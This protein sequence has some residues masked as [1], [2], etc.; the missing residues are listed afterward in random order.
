MEHKNGAHRFA[1]PLGCTK[2]APRM[3]AL[4][5]H[6]APLAACWLLLAAA[7]PAGAEAQALADAPV[8]SPASVADSL[9]PADSVAVPQKRKGFVGKFIDYFA[10]ANKRAADKKFDFGVLPGPHYSSTSGL[11]LGVVATGTY[12]MD[13]SDTLL[14]RSNVAIYGDVTT[15]GFLMTGIKGSNV[16]PHE[17][18]RMDYRFYV[19]TFPTYFWGVGYDAGNVDDNQTDYQRVRFDV[20]ARFMFRLAENTYLGPVANFQFVQAR[21]INE[22][23][24][25]RFEGCDRNVRATSAGLSF[26]FDNRDFMLN[27][28]RGWFVQLDQTFTPRFFGN[29]YRYI[30]TDLTLCTYRSVWK[31]GILAGELHTKLNYGGTPPW[32]LMSEVG[33]TS[34]MRGYYEGRYRD[35][36]ILE[37]QVELRQKIHGRHGFVV[38]AGA[39]EVF[40]RWDELR[41]GRIL[42]NFGLGYRWEFMKRVNVRIDYGFT[43]NGG[44][45]MFN[46][47]EAF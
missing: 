12:S 13:R 2:F 45:F 5:R 36:N 28:S 9:A 41:M 26:T 25:P 31:G 6:I 37:A 44:G 39:G 10:N 38:W 46:I 47:N 4:R 32:C 40:P 16:F 15:K 3:E 24:A 1:I 35:K 29:D 27:A 30:T 8:A 23:D 7:V 20:M 34:R 17:R 42:P 19:Y 33:S 11:G 43:K 22:A 14:P 18:Y 21:G